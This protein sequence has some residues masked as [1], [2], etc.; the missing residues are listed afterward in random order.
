ML[1][2]TKLLSLSS[3]L[4]IT[5]AQAQVTTDFVYKKYTWDANPKLHQLTDKEKEG[6]YVILKDKIMLELAYESSGQ[7]VE[8]S[9]RHTIIH[10]NNE[11]GIEEMNKIYVSYTNILEEMDLKGRTITSEGKIIPLSKSSVKKV[12]NIEN[13]G[14]FLIFAMEGIDK[15]GEIEYMYTNKKTA[16]TN[17]SWTLQNDAIH[18]NV[19][20]DIYSPENLIYEGRGYNGFPQFVKDTAIKEKNH[21]S[22]SIDFIDALIEEKYSSYDANKMRF[23]YQLTYNTVKGNARLYSWEYCGTDLYNAMFNFEKAETKAMD[24]LISKL[25]LSSMKTDELKVR[26]LEQF[27]KTN[28]NLSGD[29]ISIDKMLDLKYGDEFGLQRLYVGVAKAL[30]IPIEVV[31]TTD[32]TNKKFDN[33]FPSWNNLREY[34]L[35]YPGIDK[36]LASGNYS[37]RLGFPPPELTNN[38]G[39]FIKETGIGDIKTGISKVKTIESPA[40][41]NSHNNLT[42]SVTF[43]PETF[44]PTVNV[45]QEYTGYSAYYIQPAVFYM[46]ATQKTELMD[47]LSKFIGKETIVKSN[48]TSGT[49]KSD[50][51]VNPFIIESVLEVPQLIEN[52]GNKYL[53]KVGALI[54]PQEE[55]YQEKARQSDAEITYTHS[56]T[57]TINIKIPQGYKIKNPDDIKIE[58]KYMVGDKALAS[59]VS[60]YTIEGDVMK[61]HIYE[62]YQ[63][64]VYPKE[65]FEQFRS[66]INAAADFNKVVL[67]LEKA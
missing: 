1:L 43:D 20:V 37:S 2:K 32:R 25:G 54:G 28:I 27:L 24:K 34:L 30:N 59:F 31:L 65:N 18:K 48:K 42:E 11:K 51:L 39:L 53:F 21:I 3:L 33:N 50:V 35:Y 7:L 17:S 52:A 64:I 61:I 44:T 14:A 58:K 40:Y 57:R 15:G 55:L 6:N 13:A 23:D 38:K 4:F 56:F 62:D 16:S 67:I 47:N 8:Y 9:T 66:V 63:T 26:T 22:S 45:K 12:D 49:D 36:Y 41:T 46:E 10:F 60:S 29:N 19:N 5:F